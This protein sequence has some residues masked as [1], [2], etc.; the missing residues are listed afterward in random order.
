[1]FEIDVK[2]FSNEYREDD[3]LKWTGGKEKGGSLRK[4]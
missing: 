1:M 3:E 4:G 2:M